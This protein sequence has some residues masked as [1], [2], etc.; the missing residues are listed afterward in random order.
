MFSVEII[1][2]NKNNRIL[3]YN[4]SNNLLQTLINLYV[5]D[6]NVSQIHNIN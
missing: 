6:E 4:I 1:L 2:S 3:T 5:K